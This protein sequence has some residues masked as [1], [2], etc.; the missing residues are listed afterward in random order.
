MKHTSKLIAGSLT[1]AL[2]GKKIALCM[3]GSVAA[4][5]CVALARTLMRH[6]ADVHCVM[7]PSAQKIVHPYLLEWATGNPVVTELT[8]Q[9]EHITLA[10]KHSE[11]VDLVLVAPSTANTIGKI[12]H[13]IDDTPV[14]TT[15]SSAIGAKIPI[16]VVPAMHA[17]MYE[18]PAVVENLNRLRNMG[19]VVVS[20]RLEEAK[21]KIPD[22]ET[23]VE[24]VLA[25]LGPRDLVGR[26]FVVTA[27]P[28]RG[29]IDRVR[30]VSNPSS[31]KMGVE[32][33]REIIARGGTVT[34]ILGPTHISPPAL[35]ETIR[36]ETSEEMLNEVIAALDRSDTDALI[37][38]A[39]ILDFTPAHREDRKRPSGEPYAIEL[40]PTKKVIE[41]ARKHDPD[42]F[43]V[44]F[45]VESGLTDDELIRRAKAKIDS[46][47]CNLVVAND[48]QRAGVAF[49][50]DTNEVLIV[51]PSGLV[52]KV[53]LSTKREVARRV[54]DVVAHELEQ[55]G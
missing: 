55:M 15:V 52:E 54:I 3:T 39:A 36:V 11:H 26:H 23:I 6:G 31:G 25:I 5:E 33:A 17:S 21:A 18:H 37:S 43:I 50:T 24:H 42:L 44:G 30:F 48:E 47:V 40:V 2:E 51:G 20:P 49:A 34:L 29:W 53:P 1:R 28:T 22:T 9:I 12:A 27:G 46:G 13:G 16:M 32:L 10:G 19:L 8:G 35:A 38:A 7:S 4:V 45:K 14:T 41:E